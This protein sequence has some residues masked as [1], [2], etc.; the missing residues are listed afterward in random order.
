MTEQETEATSGKQDNTQQDLEEDRRAGDRK[1]Y[2]RD[3]HYTAKNESQNIVERSAPSET[4]ESA[5]RARD[6]DVG[7]PATLG[8]LPAQSERRTFIVCN[9]LCAIK[10]KRRLMAAH[11]DR[12]APCVGTARD[13]R[14]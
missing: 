4:K 10:G 1:E 13:E 5:H 6:G 9:L 3:F 2:S 14:S 7:A 8:S 11:L 12:F